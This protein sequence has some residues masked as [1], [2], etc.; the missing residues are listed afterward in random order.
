MLMGAKSGFTHERKFESGAGANQCI[1]R[2]LL[3]SRLPIFFRVAVAATKAAKDNR[4]DRTPW[5]LILLEAA[6]VSAAVNV[7]NFVIGQTVHNETDSAMLR[8][9]EEQAK[10]DA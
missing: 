8:Q 10:S 7:A 9:I 5:S 4:E 1:F 2:N 3:F 6:S